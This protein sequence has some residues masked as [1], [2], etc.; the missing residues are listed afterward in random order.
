MNSDYT[1]TAER[2][3]PSY[4]LPFAL[5]AISFAVLLVYQIINLNKQHSAMQETKQQMST[6]I[7]QREALVKQSTELQSKLQAVAVDLLALAQTN[8]KAKAIVQKYNIQQNAPAPGAQPAPS[9]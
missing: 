6:A 9:K 5:L 2:P 3:A 1:N 4:L 8:E 7:E